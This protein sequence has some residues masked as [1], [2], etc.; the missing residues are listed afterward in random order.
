[1]TAILCIS[2]SMKRLTGL[3]PAE[4]LRICAQ[5]AG[6]IVNASRSEKATATDSTTPNW[7]R[8]LPIRPF[9]NAIGRKIAMMAPVATIAA[10]VISVAPSVE[11]RTRSLPISPW[12]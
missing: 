11:A 5:R 7:K 12:R 4:R 9:M 3:D 2:R 8:N 6:V 10:K 1:M